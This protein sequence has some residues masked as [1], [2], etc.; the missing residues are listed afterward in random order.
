MLR[1]ALLML[2]VGAACDGGGAADGGV[3]R[4]VG[5]IDAPAQD[6]G[7]ADT[8]LVDAGPRPALLFHSDWSTASELGLP[9][10]ASSQEAVR[11]TNLALPWSIYGGSGLSVIASTDLDFPSPNVLRFV[12]EA[13]T[14]GFGTVRV[15]GL[16]VP[17]V[18][19]SRYYRFYL[20]VT[21]PD[22]LEDGSTHPIQDG[23][24]GSQCN[25]LFYIESNEGGPGHWQPVYGL[26]AL[27][28]GW[29]IYQWRGPILDKGVTYRFE[30]QILRTGT[31][32]FELH[33]RVYDHLGALLH[34]DDDFRDAMGSSAL[35]SVPVL[36][37]NE[38]AN[39]DGLNAGNNGVGG[40]PP[41]PFEYSIQGAFAVGAADW[42]GPYVPGEGE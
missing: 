9:L 20:R 24:A 39:L 22:G 33:V 8:P 16:P 19:E 36:H 26:D 13:P 38:V 6:V 21:A 15:T 7:A 35:S 18:G 4:D 37:F 41:F 30:H 12:A 28:N 17:A 14:T 3:E 29:P 31:D 27:S 42:I 34:D 32:T 40:T 23:N 2:F 5:A 25:W 10:P 1:P 11:D